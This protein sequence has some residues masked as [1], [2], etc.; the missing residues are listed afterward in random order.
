MTNTRSSIVNRVFRVFS[1][2]KSLKSD[3]HGPNC[4]SAPTSNPDPLF[5]S[6][7]FSSRKPRGKMPDQQREKNISS[8]RR[9][10]VGPKPSSARSSF[11]A[12]R[13]DRVFSRVSFITS[14]RVRCS[15]I[16]A[17]TTPTSQNGRHVRRR[18]RPQQG[19]RGLHRQGRQHQLHDGVAAP[20][21]QVSTGLEPR[22]RFRVFSRFS[23]RPRRSIA[24]HAPR[25]RAIAPAQTLELHLFGWTCACARR[26]FIALDAR[27]L[28]R[29]RR[30][31][32]A[33][34]SPSDLASY[35]LREIK[36]A[37]PAAAARL[38][39]RPGSG[40]NNS[41]RSRARATRSPA[42]QRCVARALARARPTGRG[43]AFF[44]PDWVRIK[45]ARALG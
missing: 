17:R 6:R 12:S 4:V 5:S 9:K 8:N 27:L 30:R 19:P 3:T 40:M 28:R 23:R 43:S 45:D 18:P 20:R 2:L 34:R 33:A 15:L 42:A 39:A 37:G 26:P 31:I 13:A 14:D 22:P 41:P 25:P 21:Q 35:P 7:I 11:S 1:P 32:N 10:L 24:E 16:P 38:S 29:P 44:V 36:P